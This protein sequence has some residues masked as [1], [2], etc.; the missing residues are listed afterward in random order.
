V[1]YTDLEVRALYLARLAHSEQ[2][3]RDGHPH[4][5][6]VCRVALAV[7]RGPAR[8]VAWLHDVVEDS[9][10][11]LERL[12]AEGF[13]DDVV[14]AV[15]ALSRRDG[16]GYADYMDRVVAAGEIAMVVKLA[17]AT[18]NLRRSI[19]AGEESAAE[20][21]RF[22]ILQVEMAADGAPS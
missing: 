13:P 6:H 18:D 12:R 21:Y 15:D 11:D 8:L 9:F 17:D 7:P 4:L 1:T 20:R 14:A 10:V 16:E 5:D 19:L 2:F 22:A 3:D